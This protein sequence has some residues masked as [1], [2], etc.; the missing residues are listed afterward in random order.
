MLYEIKTFMLIMNRITRFRFLDI[1]KFCTYIKQQPSDSTTTAKRIIIHKKATPKTNLQ[2]PSPKVRID[3]ETI[4]LLERLSLVDCENE[5]AVKTIESA[6]EFA[7]QIFEVDTTNV[8]PLITVLENKPLVVR[9][10]VVVEGDCRDEILKNAA[11]TE[12]H[13][14]VAPPGNIP[15]DDKK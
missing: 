3:N 10:D 13:Y 14:F 11:V 7:E 12:D 8:D 1:K 9:E 4:A 2:K 15:L 5:Q 6:L